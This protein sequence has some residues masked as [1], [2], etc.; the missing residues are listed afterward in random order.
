MTPSRP[1][2]GD[3]VADHRQALQWIPAHAARR[4]DHVT[5]SAVARRVR[6][7]TWIAG[8]SQEDL[9]PEAPARRDRPLPVGTRE[10]KRQGAS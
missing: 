1:V 7:Q 5:R 2:R 6:L 4:E 9:E 3:H 8:L 10:T